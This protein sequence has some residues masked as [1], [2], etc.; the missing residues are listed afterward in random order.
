[1]KAFKYFFFSAIAVGIAVIF[2]LFS[3]QNAAQTQL[4]LFNYST[5]MFPVSGY[6]MITFFLGM[7]FAGTVFSLGL[8][9]MKASKMSLQKQVKKYERELQQLRNQPLDEVPQNR[10]VEVAQLVEEEV[11]V[12]PHYLQTP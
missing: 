3:I 8:I 2:V 7:L 4:H 10:T 1:M 5:P 9:K 6:V 12:P 11:T